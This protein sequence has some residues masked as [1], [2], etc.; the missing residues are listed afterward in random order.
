MRFSEKAASDKAEEEVD[1]MEDEAESAAAL[2]ASMEEQAD[3]QADA[4]SSS[5]S[6]SSASPSTLSVLEASE[7]SPAP[8][9]P[10]MNERKRRR[11]DG[12]WRPAGGNFVV[13]PLFN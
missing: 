10:A 8:N 2:R 4:A 12:G 1:A 7:Q 13:S 9:P 3:A 6:S 5:S 11:A